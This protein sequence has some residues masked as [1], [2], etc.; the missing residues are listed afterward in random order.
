MSPNLSHYKARVLAMGCFPL[1]GDQ[2]N[3]PKNEW[4]EQQKP[5]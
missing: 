1:S 4:R 2:K 5:V 3:D